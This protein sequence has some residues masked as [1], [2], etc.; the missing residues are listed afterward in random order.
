MDRWRRSP[1]FESRAGPRVEDDRPGAFDAAAAAEDHFG[2]E[3]ARR[4]VT[5][6]VARPRADAEIGPAERGRYLRDGSPENEMAVDATVFE[7]DRVA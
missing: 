1:T 7:I 2:G 4:S 5:D 3:I 6:A